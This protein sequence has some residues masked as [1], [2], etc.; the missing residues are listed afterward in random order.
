MAEQST[1]T[2]AFQPSGV[3]L[4][5][6]IHDFK[7]ATRS[8]AA[9]AIPTTTNFF[10]AAPSS[11]PTLD[12]Y[13]QS[14]TLVSSGKKFTIYQ[15]AVH[16]WKNT[17]DANLA[18]LQKI[19][20]NCFIR[21]VT[22]SKEFGVYPVLALPIGGGLAIQSGQVAVTPAAAPGAFSS[23]GALNGHPLR[24]RFALKFPLE[25]QSNQQFYA[26]LLGPQATPL[27]LSSITLIRLELEGVEERP[28]A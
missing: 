25:I 4:L 21:L 24:K 3:G 18:D 9:A 13:D 8:L 7:Y 15:M 5:Q 28:A 6:Q 12:R 26:E 10:G 17:A 1:P 23:Q 16:I 19:I 22:A 20:D 14:G 11:D 2:R 27:T